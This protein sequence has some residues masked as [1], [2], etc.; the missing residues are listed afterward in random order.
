MHS[1]TSTDIGQKYEATEGDSKGTANNQFDP[2]LDTDLINLESRQINLVFYID[3]NSPE[4]D[5]HKLTI[6]MVIKTTACYLY[7]Q[8]AIYHHSQGY[9][10]PFFTTNS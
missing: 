8:F 7:Q 9:I 5:Q 6:I 3:H 1:L 10:F 4:S 2:T